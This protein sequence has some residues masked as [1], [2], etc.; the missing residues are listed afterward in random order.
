MY[1]DIPLALIVLWCFQFQFSIRFILCVELADPEG[2]RLSGIYV[3]RLRGCISSSSPIESWLSN[4]NFMKV[5]ALTSHVS[6][7]CRDL[8]VH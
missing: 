7:S 2:A 5:V 3:G 1:E 4:I 8:T 6:L